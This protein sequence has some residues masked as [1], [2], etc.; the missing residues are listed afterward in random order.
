MASSLTR[1]TVFVGGS[2]HSSNLPAAVKI[3]LTN[4]ITN[5]HRVI[6]GDASGADAAAQKHFLDSSYGDVTVFCSGRYPRNNLGHWPVHPVTPPQG[7]TGFG[8][9]AAKDRAMA[10]A[11]DFGF[12]IWDGSSAGTVLNVLRLVRAQK[13]AVLFNVPQ[14]TIINVKSPA[15]WDEFLLGCSD[16]LR[17]DLRD[18]AT[19]EEWAPGETRMRQTELPG[20]GPR[21]KGLKG[22]L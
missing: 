13:I 17:R 4:I 2:R 6:I 8:F 21:V 16:T 7:A 14:N 11:A 15:Q 5:G 20:G 12:M 22:V 19:A 10:L 9:Y 3:R 1:S 18:R